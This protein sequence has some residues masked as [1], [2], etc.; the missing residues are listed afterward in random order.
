MSHPCVVNCYTCGQCVWEG[1]QH[2]TDGITGLPFE[3]GQELLTAYADAHCTRD[4]CPHTTHAVAA[5]AAQSPGGLAA[6]L[7]DLRVQ[8]AILKEQGVN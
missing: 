8:F 1:G 7:A 2:T 3:D 4:T 5:E 6:Q